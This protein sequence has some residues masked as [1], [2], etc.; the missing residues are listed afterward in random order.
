MSK[1]EKQYKLFEVVVEHSE[2]KDWEHAKLEW[3]DLGL[4]RIEN[5]P[6]NA[7]D[8]TCVCGKSNLK[9]MYHIFNEKTEETLQPIGDKCIK[10]F[11]NVEFNNQLNILKLL[12]NLKTAFKNNETISFENKE[13]KKLLFSRKSIK[14]LYEEGAFEGNEYNEYDPKNDY[15]FLLKMFNRRSELTIKMNQKVEILLEKIQKFLLSN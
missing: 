13:Q 7:T 8:N 9:Y 4:D 15:K 3:I 5:D 10:K 12:E 11:D 2:S 14:Y 1:K 6:F